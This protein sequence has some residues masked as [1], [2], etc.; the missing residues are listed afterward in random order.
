MRPSCPTITTASRGRL[1]QAPEHLVGLAPISDVALAEED[2]GVT[3]KRDPPRQDLNVQQCAVLASTDGLTA[4][5]R[6]FGG[7][8]QQRAVFLPTVG[9]HRELLER[10]PH[11]FIGGEPEHRVRA[12][13]PSHH[14]PR[15]VGGDERVRVECHQRI[16]NRPCAHPCCSRDRAE[17]TRPR[18]HPTRMD[19]CCVTLTRGQIA[20]SGAIR[21]AGV[22]IGIQVANWNEAR[23]ERAREQYPIGLSVFDQRSRRLT[24]HGRKKKA[25]ELPPGPRS[26]S[27]NAS[28]HHVPVLPAPPS[29]AR[30]CDGQWRGRP[31]RGRTMPAWRAQAPAN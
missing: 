22:V 27:D 26:S 24:G 20:A 9:W 6:H 1:E 13:V 23:I 3:R 2:V 30:G 11:G 14:Q 12:T 19:P 8:T 15:F 18:R 29:S 31:G 4:H 5:G 16:V 25:R 17:R 28:R 7:A 21:L 10:T